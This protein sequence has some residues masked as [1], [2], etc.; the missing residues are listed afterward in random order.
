VKKVFSLVAGVVITFCSCAYLYNHLPGIKAAQSDVSQPDATQTPAPATPESAD[1]KAVT[2]VGP[3]ADY[4]QGQKPPGGNSKPAKD[5]KPDASDL[6]GDSP[7]GTGGVIV[8]KTFV[9]ASMAKFSFEI[10]AH[11]TSPHL[12][13]T[14]RSFLR[15]ADAA[16]A[17]DSANVEFLLMNEQQYADFQRGSQADVVYFVQSSHSQ[18]VNFDLSPTFAQPAQYCLVFR[19]RSGG[20]KKIVQADFSVEY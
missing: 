1:D 4:V 7:T 16:A 10:P 14:Y 8:Q 18:Q 19:N 17:D 2:L 3:L 11:A 13:G 5:W 6:V 15:P 20:P 9:V 12:R